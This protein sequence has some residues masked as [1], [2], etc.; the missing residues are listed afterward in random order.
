M[1]LPM[2]IVVGGLV[3]SQTPFGQAI[4]DIY[5]SGLLKPGVEQKTF[6][7]DLDQQLK[8]MFEAAQSYHQSEEMLPTA[9]EWM[10]QISKRLKTDDLLPGESEKKLV[11]PDLVGKQNQ[12]G[13]AMNAELSEKYLGDLKDESVV[14]FYESKQTERNATGNPKDDGKANGKGI[15]VRGEIV[16]LEN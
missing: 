9:R 6:A 8:L 11:R 1:A 2:A 4:G 7:S 3:L 15:N 16:S 14:L 10:D 12:F 13:F 5:S